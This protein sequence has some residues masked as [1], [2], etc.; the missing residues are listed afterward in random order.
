MLQCTRSMYLLAFG[1]RPRRWATKA[2]CSD[3]SQADPLLHIPADPPIRAS[4]TVSDRRPCR[5]NPC[6]P[7]PQVEGAP[8]GE[9]GQFGIKAMQAGYA[10]FGAGL[11][12][13]LGNLACGVCVGIVG[14]SAALS[15]AQNATLFVKVRTLAGDSVPPAHWPPVRCQLK[16]QW[17]AAADS[18]SRTRRHAEVSVRELTRQV[19]RG[20]SAELLWLQILVIEIFGS[21][22]G[23]FGVIV[24][25]IMSGAAFNDSYG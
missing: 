24:G 17:P 4:A 19:H 16:S 14:S 18:T 12:T 5:R 21:A 13:G 22:L 2:P 23:L 10:T 9:D 6:L 11:T 7:S 8:L 3:A 1:A 20:D 25:I 15:D